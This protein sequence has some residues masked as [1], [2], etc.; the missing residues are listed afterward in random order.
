MFSE[1]KLGYERRT[2][3]WLCDI[4]SPEV[5]RPEPL[6]GGW[7]RFQIPGR[8]IVEKEVFQISSNVVVLYEV[9]TLCN[10]GFITLTGV[11]ALGVDRP[12]E[13]DGDI[14]DVGS[15]VVG[16]VVDDDAGEDR[17]VGSAPS[18]EGLR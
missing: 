7:W 16:A 12:S 11:A 10:V 4:F 2:H 13:T 1:E 9:M 5:C 17:I 15:G 18:D 3:P 6:V 14:S 8:Q